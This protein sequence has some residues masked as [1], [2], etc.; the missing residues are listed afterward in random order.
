MK[1]LMMV[2]AVVLALALYGGAALGQQGMQQQGGGQGQAQGQGGWFCPWCGQQSGQMGPGMM[3]GRGQMG[4]GMQGRGMMHGP[5][6]QGMMHHGYGMGRGMMHRGYGPGQ[7]MGP[8]MMHHGWGRGQ[9]PS[10]QG[11]QM[12]VM[13]K[14]KVRML[15]EEYVA[16]NPNLKVGEI[17]EQEELYMGRIETKDGSLVERILVDKE[18][19]WMKK[20]Y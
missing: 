14:G 17:E 11:E 6:G 13:S 5:Q 10:A 3:R 16:A 19:G 12:Q 4:P 18:T 20:A 9:Y 7:Q 1:R 2:C 8:G 15:L